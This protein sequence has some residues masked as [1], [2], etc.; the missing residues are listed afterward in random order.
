[1][2]QIQTELPRQAIEAFCRKWEIVRME[3]FGSVLRE[4]FRSESDIDFLV[5]FAPE[6]EWSLFDLVVMQGELETLLGRKVDL[7]ERRAVEK[8]TNWIRRQEILGT[9]REYYAAG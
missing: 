5:T 2:G 1:M 4:D 3:L 6:A 9:A 8:S 7:V